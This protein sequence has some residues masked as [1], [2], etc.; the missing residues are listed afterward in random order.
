MSQVFKSTNMEKGGVNKAVTE[1]RVVSGTHSPE[2]IWGAWRRPP[3]IGFCPEYPKSIIKE[4]GLEVQ[5]GVMHNALTEH[6]WSQS[7]NPS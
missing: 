7:K 6:L 4:L 5:G 3:S 2:T 1:E